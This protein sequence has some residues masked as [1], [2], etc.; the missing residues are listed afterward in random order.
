[1]RLCESVVFAGLFWVTVPA[2]VPI[3]GRFFAEK[4]F[5]K[6]KI[7]TVRQ[8][9]INNNGASRQNACGAPFCVCSARVITWW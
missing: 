1:M 9:T 8:H 4:L 6:I 2:L 7:R 5:A 3:K